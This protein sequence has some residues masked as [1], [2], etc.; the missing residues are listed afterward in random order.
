M[1]DPKRDHMRCDHPIGDNAVALADGV[2]AAFDRIDPPPPVH[3]PTAAEVLLRRVHLA[4][5]TPFERLS[6]PD[7]AGIM[8]AF[9]QGQP[10]VDVDP[11]EIFEDPGLLEYVSRTASGV[12]SQ[13][14]IN[15]ARRVLYAWRAVFV[16]DRE[17]A[18][19]VAR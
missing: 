17:A 4:A 2:M 16:L 1:T 9:A 6:L 8:H 18:G 15:V 11:A 14:V 3:V 13:A 7:V 10:L 19:A 5:E 12:L